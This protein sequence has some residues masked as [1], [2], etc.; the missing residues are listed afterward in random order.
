M[1]YNAE[2]ENNRNMRS[3]VD[4]RSVTEHKAQKNL[5]LNIE[6]LELRV[7]LNSKHCVQGPSNAIYLYLSTQMLCFGIGGS[8]NKQQSRPRVGQN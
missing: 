2:T 1:S 5:Q 4:V 3:H 7:H 8:A 6:H